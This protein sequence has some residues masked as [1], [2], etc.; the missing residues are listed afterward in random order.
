MGF[1]LSFNARIVPEKR[2]QFIAAKTTKARFATSCP[3]CPHMIRVG[4]RV[5]M[6]YDLGLYA[7]HGCFQRVNYAIMR[8]NENCQEVPTA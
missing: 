5:A 1:L 4:M 6:D 3:Y 2:P 7:H 8:A